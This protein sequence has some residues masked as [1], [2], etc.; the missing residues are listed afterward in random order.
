MRCWHVECVFWKAMNITTVQVVSV[1][2]FTLFILPACQPIY[3]VWGCV[4]HVEARSEPSGSAEL[5]SSGPQSALNPAAPRLL[6][7]V[8][9]LTTG[10]GAEYTLGTGN[11]EAYICMLAYKKKTWK[12]GTKA[13][14]HRDILTLQFALTLCCVQKNKTTTTNLLT[15][16]SCKDMKS[17]RITFQCC[18]PQHSCIPL[19]ISTCSKGSTPLNFF[20]YTQSRLY[21]IFTTKTA[22]SPCWPDKSLLLWLWRGTG[23]KQS[24]DQREYLPPAASA[25]ASKCFS[26]TP[27]SAAPLPGIQ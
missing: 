17:F 10:P 4:I 13:L 18:L 16:S 2:S 22:N 5:L 6:L 20:S 12:E 26:D 8:V 11:V 9:S 25:A 24:P 7:S 1:I 15:H 27:L 23:I 3:P 19:L 21:K 14:I